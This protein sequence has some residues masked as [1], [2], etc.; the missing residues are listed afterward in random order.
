[1]SNLRDEGLVKYVER[2]TNEV[3]RF[4]SMFKGSVTCIPI[5][6][7]PLC[8]IPDAE[9][10][11]SLYDYSLWLDGLP[12]YG[13]L[14]YNSA[15]RQLLVNT[16]TE[17][18][19]HL[20]GRVFMQSSLYEFEPKVFERQGWLGLPGTVPPLS[21]TE[22]KA[23]LT[24]LLEGLSTLFKL[25]LDTLPN[26]S[27]DPSIFPPGSAPAVDEMA[28]LFIGA[29]N[30]DRLANSAASLGI[31]T[32]T[33]T[34]GGWVLTTDAVTEILPQVAAHCA[35]LAADSPVV[36]YCLDN[37][38]FCCADKDGQLTAISKKE[39]GIYHVIGE[40]VVVHEVTLAAAVTNLKR[41]ILACGDRRVIIITPGPR[42]LTQPCCCAAGHSVHILV[43][44]AG[45][46]MMSDL[47][48]LHTFIQRRLGSSPNCQVIPACDLLA[49]KKAASVEEALAAFS[50]WG[51]IHGPTASYT[52]MA[53]AL[54]D[55]Y[56]G[57]TP[58]AA[59]VLPPRPQPTQKRPRADSSASHTSYES[60]SEAGQPI[61]ALTSFRTPIRPPNLRGFTRGGSRGSGTGN[62]FPRAPKRG[63]FDG[64]RGGRGSGGRGAGNRGK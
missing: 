41:I 21:P 29:S 34:T 5:A 12:D 47:A 11:R 31:L 2:S 63:S 28:A 61:P 17:T 3:R 20:P 43:P 13:L 49:G 23:L 55:G 9:T 54:V 14:R 39:D 33:I 36:I 64:G 52:R 27:R 59:A 10:V 62:P 26:L 38:S 44:E 60:G 53:L 25:N 45:L 50:S 48:R 57:N 32:E 22:E 42:Y 4:T 7:P 30:A 19:N 37:S 56:F 40:I 58:P 16:K 1:M 15:L 18:V 35:A 51:S 24:P 46:K 6:P 8:G